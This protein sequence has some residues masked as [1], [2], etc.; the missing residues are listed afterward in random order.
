M[1]NCELGENFELKCKFASERSKVWTY[2]IGDQN[3]VGRF[4]LISAVDKILKINVG[5]N[6]S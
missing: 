6:L 2:H 1:I 3:R 5:C 4:V